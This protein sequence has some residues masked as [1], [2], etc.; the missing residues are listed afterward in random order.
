MAKC[1]HRSNQ[2]DYGVKVT[3]KSGAHSYGVLTAQDQQTSFLLPSAQG[4]RNITLT[5]NGAS[6]SSTNHLLR[7]KNDLGNRDNI[8]FFVSHRDADDYRNTVVSGDG[9]HWF[10]KQDSLQY[11]MLLN[12][13]LDLSMQNTITFIKIRYPEIL[14]KRAFSLR[15]IFQRLLQ[16]LCLISNEIL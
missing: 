2:P 7:Y 10:S 15:M 4:S 3:G 13:C 9:N 16:E 1:Y 12:K 11:R 6:L 14:K 8:G 5:D